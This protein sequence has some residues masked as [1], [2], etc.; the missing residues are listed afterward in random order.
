[1]SEF[2][3]TPDH[4]QRLAQVLTAYL[5]AVE[6]GREPDRQG[7]LARYPDLAAELAEFFASRDQIERLT[8]PE[9]LLSPEAVRPGSTQDQLTNPQAGADSTDFELTEA[10]RD[11][12]S[13]ELIEEIG[14]GG[15]GVV[16]RARQKALHRLVALK[17]IRTGR[18]SSPADVQRFRN[19]ATTAAW[20]DHHHTVPIYEVGEHDGR[21]YFSMRL[22][23]GGSLADQ[24]ERY[25]ADPQAAARLV[26]A[27][28]RAVHHAH[29]RGILHRDLKPSNILLDADG[30]PHISDFGLS[31]WM[32]FDS[33]LTQSG[34]IV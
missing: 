30:R 28:A 9:R 29:E 10:A 7:L 18:L 8:A 34:A 13:Y 2:A 5:E 33:G 25:R 3:P 20:L 12:G 15:M 32:E 22:M 4:E 11:F 27:V 21:L 26:A 17:M 16:Y 1:M 24:L 23:E 31:K 19:E 6:Q 14:Q